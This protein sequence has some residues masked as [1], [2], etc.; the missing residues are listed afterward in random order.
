MEI[1]EADLLLLYHQQGIRGLM[2]S[3]AKYYNQGSV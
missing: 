2:K 1:D 3:K